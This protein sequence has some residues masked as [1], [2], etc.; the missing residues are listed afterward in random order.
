[1][2]QSVARI[3]IIGLGRV[4]TALGIA[5]SEAG[6]KIV[7]AFDIEASARKRFAKA[8]ATNIREM[9]DD[10][11]IDAQLILIAVPDNAIEKVSLDISRSANLSRGIL[12]GHT[13]GAFGS[14]V[15]HDVKA[16]GCPIFSM[17]P[18]QTF[19]SVDSAVK[20][21][22]D[23]YFGIEGDPNALKRVEEIVVS[24]GGR[25]VLINS[26]AKPIY[27]AALS[28]ASN[29]LVTLLGQ[30]VALFEE[31]GIERE[32]A[33]KMVLP[34]VKTTLANFEESGIRALTGPIE[35]GDAD[36]LREQVEAIAGLK[37]DLLST[38]LVLARATVATAK[39]KG[40]I[41]DEQAQLLLTTL[42]S[43]DNKA[44]E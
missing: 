1:M 33:I 17:H 2:E 8:V 7:S 5:L 11:L 22:P 20:A 30:S 21:L 16:R 3:A 19:S 42:Q 43:V 29:F 27:H 6:H 23:S 12:V 40:S 25:P 4:G 32:K 35:R 36:T 37:P 18:I 44:P 10:S 13:S 34:L 14:E 39:E 38:Y 31:A 41:T 9:L 28:A 26:D 15:L 24:I